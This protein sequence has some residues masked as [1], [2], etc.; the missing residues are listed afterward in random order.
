VLPFVGALF[1]R[2]IAN[3]VPFITS[4]LYGGFVAFR[5]F[6]IEES[7]KPPEPIVLNITQDLVSRFSTSQEHLEA[8]KLMDRFDTLQ[9]HLAADKII[10]RYRSSREQPDADARIVAKIAYALNMRLSG[11]FMRVIFGSLAYSLLIF[12]IGFMIVQIIVFTR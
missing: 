1:A 4:R 8:E 11:E 6:W 7:S 5:E 2:L 3:V 9:E 10:D 12:F